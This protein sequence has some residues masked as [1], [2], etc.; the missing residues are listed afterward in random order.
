MAE[1][2]KLHPWDS[3]AAVSFLA[4]W[5]LIGLGVYGS[6]PPD[7]WAWVA[8]ILGLWPVPYVMKRFL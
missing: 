1:N 6:L 2:I 4:S 5:V 7:P 8:L 3:V